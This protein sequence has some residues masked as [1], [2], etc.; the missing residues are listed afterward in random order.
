MR[1]PRCPSPGTSGPGPWFR[2]A[3]GAQGEG[4]GEQDES[5]L[6]ERADS[7]ESPIY[8]LSHAGKVLNPCFFLCL[9]LIFLLNH[10]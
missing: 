4:E 10:D 2:M 3:P 9:T 6:F 8:Q 5:Q 1:S 7:A